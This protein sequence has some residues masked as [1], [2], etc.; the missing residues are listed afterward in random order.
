MVRHKES[1]VQNSGTNKKC[2]HK[3]PNDWSKVVLHT[4][5]ELSGKYEPVP[6]P[7]C[8]QEEPIA[9]VMVNQKS[10]S[11]VQPPRPSSEKQIRFLFHGLEAGKILYLCLLLARPLLAKD[12]GNV[13]EWL[14]QFSPACEQLVEV[15]SP[16][17]SAFPHLEE[18]T[19]GLQSTGC[20]RHP[21]PCRGQWY[22]CPGWK[23]HRHYFCFL[24][25]FLLNQMDQ[26]A[27]W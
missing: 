5:S 18:Q 2:R 27:L 6:L 15:I 19:A 22:L 7:Q 25:F 8:P 3:D 16:K 21:A 17:A 9:I 14:C 20:S 24:K 11:P 23:L 13:I 1:C 12:L 10:R 4:F 26:T